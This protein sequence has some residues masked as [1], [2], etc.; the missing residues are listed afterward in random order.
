MVI[1]VKVKDLMSNNIIYATDKNTL[2]DVSSLM[3]T[4]DIGF[5][6]IKKDNDYVGVITDR[7]IIIKAIG[8]HK[9]IDTYINE[10]MS[11]KIISIDSE[12]DVKEALK[13]MSDYQIRRLMVVHKKNYVGVLSLSD[14]LSVNL[15]CNVLEYI[16]NI[17]MPTNSSFYSNEI[18]LP[19]AEI[20]EFEL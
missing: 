11:N 19:Q 12:E 13:L 5:L 3:K 14:I 16:T 2:K 8:N 4:Y 17:Y 9:N 20:D 6:P 10:I 1:L 7:D 15:D 18:N